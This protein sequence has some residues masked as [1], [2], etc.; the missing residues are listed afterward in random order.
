MLA[1]ASVA[2]VRELLTA[3]ASLAAERWPL[4]RMGFSSCAAQAYRPGASGIF[5]I[6]DP[7]QVPPHWQVD[8]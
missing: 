7:T 5:P 4:G 6:R 1:G 2:A 3:V 8:S